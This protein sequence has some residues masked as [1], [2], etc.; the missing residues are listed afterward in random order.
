MG[1]RYSSLS[2]GILAGFFCML[3]D[4]VT[5]SLC[6]FH[7]CLENR[8]SIPVLMNFFVMG[9]EMSTWFLKLMDFPSDCIVKPLFYLFNCYEV[10]SY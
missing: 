5:H 1:F 8:V 7:S 10:V 3:A 6:D 9:F 4:L 2:C